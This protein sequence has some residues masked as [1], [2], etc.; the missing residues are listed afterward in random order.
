MQMGRIMSE[1]D[2]DGGGDGGA[3]DDLSL[4]DD[5]NLDD[6]LGAGGDDDLEEGGKGNPPTRV[7][8]PVPS[9]IDP[10]IIAK[11]VGEAVR[12]VLPQQAPPAMSEEEF[13]KATQY[14]AVNAD[15]AKQFAKVLGVEVDDARAGEL[16]KLLQSMIDGANNHALK[17]AGIMLG[18]T[19]EKYN[20]RVAD[21]ETRYQRQQ[22]DKFIDQ[23]TDKFPALK[24]YAQ[25]LPEVLNQIKASGASPKDTNEAIKLV[26]KAARDHI[27]R[28]VPNF[29]T[30]ENP[31]VRRMAGSL[32]GNGASTGGFG[33]GGQTKSK[34]A[35]LP[36]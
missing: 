28:F 33:A 18:V 20:K 22:T 4:D 12:G 24:Q 9:A 8:S 16:S 36:W 34:A 30:A 2:D 6:D 25:V 14:Y 32:T 17:T 10:Q 7:P 15:F 11:A 13:R 19:D 23:V 31:G 35:S 1:F 26:A 3:A 29:M 5:S 27:R 21:L